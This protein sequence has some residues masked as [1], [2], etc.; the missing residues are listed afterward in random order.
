[1]TKKLA[2]AKIAET[3]QAL[4]GTSATEYGGLVSVISGL[5]DQAHRVLARL[6]NA[7]LTATY[8]EIGRRIVEHSLAEACKRVSGGIVCLLS[9]LR[10]HGL[11]TQ[12][13]W[14]VWMAITPA[15][16]KPKLD[17]PP[18]RV[19]RFSGKEFTE[20]IECRRI[21]GV[22]GRIYSAA[23]A[24]ADC[25][26]YR[27]KVGVDIAV[28]ALRDAWQK[29]K[30]AAEQISHFSQVCRVTNVMRPCLDSLLA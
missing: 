23:K 8:W 4:A 29:R 24:V 25:F 1:V 20:G 26:K 22:D 13:S 12:N 16:R 6:T 21:E 14:E 7:I 27:R 3:K 2:K 30:I 15:S 5:L 18:L 17:H 9:A 10:Y 19:V 28:Q 11:T